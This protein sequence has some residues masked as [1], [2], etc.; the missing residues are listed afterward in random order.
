MFFFFFFQV[1]AFRILHFFL[2]CKSCE[3]GAWINPGNVT[4]MNE[5]QV[6]LKKIF[7]AEIMKSSFL[8]GSFYAIFGF[9]LITKNKI[10]HY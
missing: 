4:S 6:F 9:V 2:S 3:N 10:K 1:S 5:I 8:M 7:F